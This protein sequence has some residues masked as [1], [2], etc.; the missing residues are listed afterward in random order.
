MKGL[1]YED[2]VA[3]GRRREREAVTRWLRGQVI[4]FS[5]VAMM[6]VGGM[7]T[8]LGIGPGKPVRIYAT[9][10]AADIGIGKHVDIAEAAEDIR[11]DEDRVEG[12]ERNERRLV[13]EWLRRQNHATLADQLEREAHY[14]DPSPC[15]LCGA[16]DVC[17]HSYPGSLHNP[18]RVGRQPPG[19]ES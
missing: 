11:R 10:L 17:K 13:I 19:Q 7:A 4:E 15:E 18:L 12:I 3:D 9:T 5:S 8:L 1:T 2:G 14:V 6:L 16:V